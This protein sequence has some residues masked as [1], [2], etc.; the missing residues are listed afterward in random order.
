M[1]IFL[2]NF[3]ILSISRLL[4][5]SILFISLINV[6][7]Y[8]LDNECTM[9]T[10][11]GTNWNQW[12][13]KSRGSSWR[14][15]TMHFDAHPHGQPCCSCAACSSR[16]IVS[17][18]STNRARL[19]H[20]PH[21]PVMPVVASRFPIDVLVTYRYPHGPPCHES[22]LWTAATRSPRHGGRESPGKIGGKCGCARPARG[23][24]GNT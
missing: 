14:M 2:Y 23:T 8:A 15:H 7:R 3:Y 9:H 18:A 4:K 22:V 6:T 20:D 1:R 11:R 19:S 17:R 5:T 24:R 13:G 12:A 16:S 21:T 10:K